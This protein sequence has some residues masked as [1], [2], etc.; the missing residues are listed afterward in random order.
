MR[1]LARHPP[2]SLLNKAGERQSNLAICQNLLGFAA[3]ATLPLACFTTNHPSL[4]V[5]VNY[6]SGRPRSAEVPGRYRGRSRCDRNGFSC[7]YTK[8]GLNSERRNKA[9]C[10]S[11]CRCWA[12]DMEMRFG[13]AARIFTV[14]F[15][16]EG[17]KASKEDMHFRKRVNWVS[18][19]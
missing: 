2:A 5:V 13:D 8:R 7:C 16:R 14:I 17:E 4:P 6:C 3:H 15:L 19:S 9:A 1:E 12:I 18:Q 11:T 10:F